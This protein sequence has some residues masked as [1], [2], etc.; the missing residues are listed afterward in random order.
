M[1][2]YKGKGLLSFFL[3]LTMMFGFGTQT[4]Q[5]KD[6]TIEEVVVTGSYIKRKSQ[7]DSA[8]PITNI[9]QSAM[10]DAGIFT[11]QELFRWLPSNT[12]SENQADALTQGGTPGTA[13]VN[14]RGLGLGSTLV[15]LNNRRQTV[16]SAVANRGATFVD[17]NSLVPMIMVQNVE[18]LKDGAAAI[19]G[20]DAVAGVVNYKTRDN[21]EGFEIR[22]NY[23]QANSSESD[24]LSDQEISMLF[25]AQ[26]DDTSIV[27]GA[28]FF[29]RTGLGLGERDLPRKTI[30][31]FGQPGSFLPLGLSPTLPA[32]VPGVFNADPSCAAGTGSFVIPTGGGSSLCGFDFG[33]SYSLVPDEKRIQ[34][35]AV[36]DHTLN[37]RVNIRSEIGYARNEAEGG[38]SPSFP[39][40]SFPR[41][42]ADHPG[43]P[44]GVTGVTRFRVFGDGTGAP[45]SG[46]VLNSA[47]HETF[48]FVLDVNGDLTDN[49]SYDLAYT[50]SETKLAI[51]GGD[52]SKSRLDLALA[53]FGGNT[54]NPTSGTAGV[55]NCLY[56]NP[57]GTALTAQPGDPAYNTAEVLNFVDSENLSNVTTDLTT[58]DFVVSGDL[59]EMP[60]GTA[61]IALGYQYREEKRKAL[62]SDDANRQDLVFLIGN[63]SSSVDRD[64]NAYFA[65]V[66]LPLMDNS[67]LGTLEAQ[68]A[69]RYEDYSTDYDSTDPKIGLLWR[70]PE[71]TF[72]GRMTIGSAFRAPTI[73]QQFVKATSLNATSDP[74][75]GSLVFL[76]E[77]ASPN[78]NLEPEEADTFTMGVT[79]Q[80]M[81]NLRVSLDYWNV[82]YENRLSQE[83]GQIL[84]ITEA[85]A[86]TA[87]GCTAGTL[88]TAP[89][90][91]I[92][93]Q[94]IVRDP[95]TGTP[96]RIFVNRFNAAE[97]ETDGFDIDVSYDF[98]TDFGEFRIM[99]QSTIVS[100]FDLKAN[101]GGVTIDG[102]GK[103]NESNT[104]ASP[105]PELRSNTTFSWSNEAHS[106][107][108]VAR[109][110]DSYEE[111]GGAD[112]DDWWIFDLQYNYN[113]SVFEDDS[114]TVTLGALNLTDE[115]PPF[116][117][118]GDNEFGYDT[119]THDP[120]GRMLYARFI[121]TL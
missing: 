2:H 71:A 74:L 50:W 99:N 28:K 30:S 29:D 20:S 41:V 110:I 25:G 105:I 49:W 90:A 85:A 24:D 44:Y 66:F 118:G 27:I 87:A 104:L 33:D 17:I 57:F 103:R 39:V 48:R 56:Y 111:D 98:S 40:L 11:S 37:D 95:L 120:R 1:T 108:L 64:T 47:D 51:T 26:G 107:N 97:A 81:D 76:G 112:V 5:A 62:N 35:Y 14:L 58:I 43:N 93:D 42:A 45:G 73:F 72:A 53:G 63:P 12:G 32:T 113:F 21:F 69:V 22:M 8:S 114:A 34:V 38:Y 117:S 16:S 86:L 96:L 83:S 92:R 68:L 23:M 101:A 65:E 116:V 54:C 106:V 80:A 13:N 78:A 4:A 52:Q 94:K 75:T 77:T 46:R 3:Y 6:S 55:G 79:W 59:F 10:D 19:Y 84:I 121:Y 89:C 15:L 82:Q 7:L 115:E 109:Y 61:G 88:G 36:I 60:A 31:S 119:K 91:A 70:S 9:D 100:S 102:A 67:D 18:I